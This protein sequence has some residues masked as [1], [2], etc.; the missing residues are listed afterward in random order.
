MSTCHKDYAAAADLLGQDIPSDGI[1]GKTNPCDIPT[2][3]NVA[4]FTL[5]LLSFF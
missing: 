2:A 3:L 4:G 5:M 1:F